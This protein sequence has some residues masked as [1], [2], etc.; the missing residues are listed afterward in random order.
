MCVWVPLATVRT[1]N[2]PPA[3]QTRVVCDED[4]LGDTSLSSPSVGL[5]G[6]PAAEG[7]CSG[8]CPW[9][10]VRVEQGH[11]GLEPPPLATLQGPSPFP[12]VTPGGAGVACVGRG[13]SA[14][15]PRG[16]CNCRTWS[17]SPD[18]AAPAKPL[19]LPVLHAPAPHSPRPR[20]LAHLPPVTGVEPW[21]LG[22]AP[23]RQAGQQ[24][25]CPTVEVVSGAPGG[26]QG[27]RGAAQVC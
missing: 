11:R 24:G 8:L 7:G 21:P 20:G 15:C 16:P 17:S 19:P 10:M 18:R 1:V 23:Q 25:E 12:P 9:L 22:Q 5:G 13:T 4:K 2:G 6:A 14:V 3:L 26:A 27:V